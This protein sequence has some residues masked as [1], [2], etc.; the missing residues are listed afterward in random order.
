MTTDMPEEIHVE[1]S[2]CGEDCCPH[3]AYSK[4]QIG[5]QKF[6]KASKYDELKA[7]CTRMA[8]ALEDISGANDV[9]GNSPQCDGYE[10]CQYTAK[11]A[12]TEYNNFKGVG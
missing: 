6:V 5:T 7:L 4:Q 2:S 12:L 3:I 1:L 9:D 11:K 10:E 8:T